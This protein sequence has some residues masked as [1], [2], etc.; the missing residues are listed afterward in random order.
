M[1][2]IDWIAEAK[3]LSPD[4]ASHAKQPDQHAGFMF[5]IK[6]LDVWARGIGNTDQL[7][8]KDAVL[9]L[10][11]LA[12]RVLPEYT[13]LVAALRFELDSPVQCRDWGPLRKALAR[14]EAKEKP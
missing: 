5:E 10:R 1:A 12:L 4:I 14:I 7:A 11:A 2:E 9:R 3:R 13:E 8:A 6:F